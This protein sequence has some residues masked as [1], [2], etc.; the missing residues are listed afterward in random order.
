MICVGR[1]DCSAALPPKMIE[2]DTHDVY[3]LARA[4]L[5]RGE[6]SRRRRDFAEVIE[7]LTRAIQLTADATEPTRSKAILVEAYICRGAAWGNRGD[8]HKAVADFSQAIAIHPDRALAYYNRGLAWHNKEDL[9]RAI[10][11]Y[12]RVTELDPQN[13]A[14]YLQRGWAWKTLNEPH[15]AASDFARVKELKDQQRM[16]KNERT[17]SNHG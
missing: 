17:P 16:A 10:T 14:A 2:S 11:D 12:S 3:E 6:E 7:Q 15:K 1:S 4:D 13:A 8:A 5:K 9:E